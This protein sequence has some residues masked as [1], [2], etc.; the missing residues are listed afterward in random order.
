MNHVTY[1]LKQAAAFLHMS[2]SAIRQKVKEGR[3]K[4]VKP[5]KRWVFLESDLVMYL[6]ALYSAPGNASLSSCEQEVTL[7][8]ST[9]AATP[10]GLESQPPTERAY[11]GLLGLKTKNTRRSITTD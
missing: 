8:H 6:Q 9:N 1:S 2:P 10:G 4:G 7:C 11:A 5:A 3:I